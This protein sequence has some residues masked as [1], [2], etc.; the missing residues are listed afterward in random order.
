MSPWANA[1]APATAARP[2][3]RAPSA[4]RRETWHGTVISRSF[5][6]TRALRP[7]S[8]GGDLR[9]EVDGLGLP[10]RIKRAILGRHRK[11]IAI[12]DRGHDALGLRLE[13]RV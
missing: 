12:L 4:A 6:T 2:N 7:E 3:A 11:R 10:L 1:G 9:I 8:T 5:R 13:R